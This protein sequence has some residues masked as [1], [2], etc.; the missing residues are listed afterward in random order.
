MRLP[1]CGPSALILLCLL[2][3]GGASIIV[4][5]QNTADAKACRDSLR[6]PDSQTMEI[7]G[8]QGL[9]RFVD[10]ETVDVIGTILS[11]G[12]ELRVDLNGLVEPDPNTRIT[13][14]DILSPSG[15][16][17]RWKQRRR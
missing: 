5:G 17:S 3:F 8:D 13:T 12:I 11:T 6:T 15:F 2:S 10:H 7:V 1:S 16:S 4:C 9:D 14:P